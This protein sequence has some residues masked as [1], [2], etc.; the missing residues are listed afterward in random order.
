MF[1]L[2]KLSRQVP[3][4]EPLQQSLWITKHYKQDV[5]AP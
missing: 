1:D 5:D 3:V 4:K 2:S